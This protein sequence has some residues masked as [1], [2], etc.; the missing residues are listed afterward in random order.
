VHPIA[1]E[2]LQHLGFPTED[3]KSLAFREALRSLEMRIRLFLS[4]PLASIERMYLKQRL[5]EIGKIPPE[6]T[7]AD[8]HDERMPCTTLADEPSSYYERVVDVME[9]LIKFTL[10]T[11]DIAPYLV[12]RYSERRETAEEL[13]KRVNLRSI[14][15]AMFPRYHP[16]WSKTPRPSASSQKLP[17][18]LVALPPEWDVA[19]RC[20]PEWR[21][22]WK[23][24]ESD[25]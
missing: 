3:L 13:S 16:T 8:D 4:L 9:E 14:W 15:S 7:W 20:I 2:L 18:I 10:L 21:R 24:V 17:T 5:D 11:R 25:T 22:V 6:S 23:P 19:I 1:L 12:D